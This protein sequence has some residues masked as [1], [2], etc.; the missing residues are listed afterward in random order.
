MHAPCDPNLEPKDMEEAIRRWVAAYAGRHGLKVNPDQRVLDV[1]IR[2]LARN[3]KRFGKPYC[4][5]RL[6]TGDKEKDREIE[7][8]CVFHQEEID[9]V[10]HCHCNLFF[11]DEGVGETRT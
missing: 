3:C 11:S 10:G 5:C 6:R 2:G 1:V 4:P 9:T 7:C 8:P